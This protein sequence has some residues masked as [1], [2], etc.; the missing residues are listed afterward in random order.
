MVGNDAR[1]H[2]NEAT[3]WVNDIAS[4]VNDVTTASGDVALSVNDVTTVSKDAAVTRRGRSLTTS[5][6]RP[7]TGLGA[8]Y[9]S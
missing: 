4:S 1:D 9:S 7:W 5:S 6:G 8:V 3:N 2:V